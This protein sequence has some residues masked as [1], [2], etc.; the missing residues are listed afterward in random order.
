MLANRGISINHKLAFKFSVELKCRTYWDLIKLILPLPILFLTNF[1]TKHHL[2]IVIKVLLI[3]GPCPFP[4]RDI[5]ENKLHLK[6]FFKKTIGQIS[7]K[8]GTKHSRV[9]EIQ[10]CSNERIILSSKGR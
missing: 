4:R 1:G 3:E 7:T 8:L 5:G 6:I 10:V 9:K 2:E